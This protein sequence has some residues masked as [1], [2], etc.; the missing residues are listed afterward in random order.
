MNDREPEH[1]YLTFIQ[2]AQKFPSFSEGS[3][4]FHRS[5]NTNGFNNCVRK[6]GRKCLIKV[7]EFLDWIEEQTG[8][9]E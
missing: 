2:V 9:N 1:E 8:K 7:S 4:R 6:I 5:N 3:L